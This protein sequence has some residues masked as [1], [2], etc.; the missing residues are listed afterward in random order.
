MSRWTAARL[1]KMPTTSVRAPDLLVEPLLRVVRPDLLPVGHGEGGEGQDVGAC[2][3]QQRRRLRETLIEHAHHAG[4][5][6][7]DVFR[8]GLLIDRPDHRRHPRLGAARDLGEQVRH[9]VGA[10]ALP[11]G[12]GEDGRD[13]VLQ[14]LVRIGGHQL[15]PTQ[16]PGDQ[17][18]QERQPEGAVLARPDVD[19]EH[20]ALPLAVDRGRHHD[21][22]VDDPAVLAHLLGQRVQPQVGIR[23]AVQRPAEE[24]A[25]H[26]SSSWQIR[27]TWLFEMPSQPRACTRSST[28]RVETPST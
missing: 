12:P 10:A 3:R 18:A 20:L 11:R 25:H 15:H 9:E 19:A 7:V 22:D 8:R 27:E 5:L 28:R 1:G 2:I 21:T 23:P 24:R 17:R 6:A 4:V 13:G 26:P 14:A 16:T